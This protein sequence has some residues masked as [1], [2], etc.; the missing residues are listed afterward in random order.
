MI[1]MEA[2]HYVAEIQ[3]KLWNDI[4]KH[5]I[6]YDRFVYDC[7]VEKAFVAGVQL[8]VDIQTAGGIEEYKKKLNVED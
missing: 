2:K 1:D 8:V 7:I 4:G 3:D 5:K 6:G